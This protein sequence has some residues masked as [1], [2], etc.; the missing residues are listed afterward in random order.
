M[1]FVPVPNVASVAFRALLDGKPVQTDMNFLCDS[2]ITQENLDDLL[3]AACIAWTVGALPQL[4]STYRFISG[5]AYDAGEQEGLAADVVFT[6]L[7]IGTLSGNAQPSNVSLFINN[8]IG[9]RKRGNA[10]GIYWPCFV[11]TEV[12]NNIISQSRIDSIIV[13]MNEF[14]GLGAVASGWQL[15]AVSKFLNNLP[16]AVGIARKVVDYI[17][18]DNIVDSM[19]RRLPKKSS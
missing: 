8:R 4:P 10:G 2:A 6:G 7:N 1:P 16:R 14:V 13:F 11:E 3:A 18:N 9:T 19:R 15:V 12:T 17:V 5:Y